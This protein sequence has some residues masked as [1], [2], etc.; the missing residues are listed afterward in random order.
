MELS[1]SLL[2]QD[3]GILE[4]TV[5][6]FVRPGFEL[7]NPTVRR[8]ATRTAQRAACR[9]HTLGGRDWRPIMAIYSAQGK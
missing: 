3:F 8:A 6:L 1:N 5:L 4:K 7:L 2:Q 9:P